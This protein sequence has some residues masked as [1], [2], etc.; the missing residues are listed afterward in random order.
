MQNL[1]KILFQITDL[2]DSPP[3][4]NGLWGGRNPPP[5]NPL[6]MQK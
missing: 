3:L 1:P 2:L 4:Y 6:D 5:H